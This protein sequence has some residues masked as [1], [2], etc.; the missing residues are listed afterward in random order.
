MLAQLGFAAF[1]LVSC[2]GG[3][4]AVINLAFSP[5]ALVLGLYLFFTCQPQYLAFSMWLWMLTPFVRRVVDLHT[6]YHEQSLV[7]LAPFLVASI[8]LIT[9]VRNLPRFGTRLL[10]PYLLLM[11]VILVGVLLGAL[12]GAV[13]AAIYAALTWCAPIFLAINILC[14][15]EHAQANAER[16]FKTL[17]YGLVILGG[18]GLYQFFSP[19]AWD[20]FWVENANMGSIGSAES[21]SLRIFA[22]M[23]SPGIYA[24]MLMASLAALMVVKTPVKPLAAALGIVSFM[25]SLVR[26]AWGGFV[27]AMLFVLARAPAK[28]KVRYLVVAAILGVLAVPL[29]TVGPIADKVQSRIESLSN[30]EEDHSFQQRSALYQE[31]FAAV[32]TTVIG[33]GLGRTGVAAARLG[34]Q[35]DMASLDSGI[36]DVFFTFGI[37][38]IPLFASIFMIVRQA[39]GAARCG[40]YANA[41]AGIAIAI[42]VQLVFANVLYGPSGVIFHVFSAL[43]V[44]QQVAVERSRSRATRLM[45]G[46]G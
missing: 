19:P 42:I 11:V 28:Q 39:V 20:T 43:A 35:T 30:T 2:F 44:A 18:Y 27:I 26:S 8:S 17:A 46:R 1:V 6:G 14:R 21:T 32:L 9:V 4:S 40:P 41:S 38:A 25:L 23:N 10:F 12:Q 3:M 31:M 15:P 33:S 37:F 13:A 22:T 24:Q 29:L 7:M 34:G 45:R 5:I 16:L 36:L